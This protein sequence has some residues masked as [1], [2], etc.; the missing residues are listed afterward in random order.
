MVKDH[1]IYNR[2]LPLI[3][4]QLDIAL[5]ILQTPTGP[6]LKLEK[7]LLEESFYNTMSKV[8]KIMEWDEA[9]L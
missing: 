5:G 4:M 3:S 1:I 7:A 2:A 8:R 9:T 6:V